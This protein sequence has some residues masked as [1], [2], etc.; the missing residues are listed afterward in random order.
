M[1]TPLDQLKQQLDRIEQTLEA[2]QLGFIQTDKIKIVYCN[3]ANG[4]L[5]YGLEISSS[6]TLIP[7]IIEA[8]SLRCRLQGIAVRTATREGEECEKFSLYVQ[9]DRRYVLESGWSTVK[10]KNS[11]AQGLVWA[12]ASMTPEQLKR[13]VVLT[14]RPGTKSSVLFCRIYQDGESIYPERTEDLDLE[15]LLRLAISNLEAASGRSYRE[16]DQESER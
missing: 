13:P 12:I 4:G 14:P 6:A 10:G 5:W 1:Q 15:V 7:K 3:R 2:S 11:F 8:E 16:K 9:G